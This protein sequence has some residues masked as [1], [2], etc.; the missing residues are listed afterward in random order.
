MKIR[1]DK[2]DQEKIE[3]KEKEAEVAESGRLRPS[4][5]ACAKKG[6]HLGACSVRRNW[7]RSGMVRNAA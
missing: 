5:A 1:S 7:Y 4:G 2:F 6:G 3:E